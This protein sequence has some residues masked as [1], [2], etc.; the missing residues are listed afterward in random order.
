MKTH[1]AVGLA[2]ALAAGCGGDD[3]DDS[4][5]PAQL[6]VLECEIGIVGGGAA[7]IYTAYRLTPKL[8][9][10]VCLFEKE[11]ELGGRIRDTALD[12]NPDSPRIGAGARRVMET[13]EMLFALAEELGIEFEAPEQGS[14]LINAR[15]TFAFSRDAFLP[16]YPGVQGP[17]DEDEATDRETEL[18][19]L[20]RIGPERKN[21]GKYA[22]WRSYVRAVVG[23]EEF[24]FLRDMSRFKADF[25]Y[26][27][28]A[29]NYLSW[30]DEE[31]DTCCKLSYP[32]GGMSTYI[33]G[34]EKKTVAAGGRIYKSEPVL[35]ISRDAAGYLLRT[36]KHEVKV[37]RL[38]IA[39][40]P[41][42]L[43]HIE[44]EV[45]EEIRERPEYQALVPVRLTVINQWWDEAWWAKVQNPDATG[46]KEIWR[47]WTTEHCIN[48]IEIPIDA[49]GADQKV[50]RS[51]YNDDLFCAE[52]WEELLANE[53]I[54]AVEA[55]VVRGLDYLFNNGVSSPAMVGIPKPLK[56][57]M[58]V[59]PGGWYYVRAG[60]EISNQ[61]I[62][63]WSREPLPGEADVMLVGEAYWPQRPGWSIGA[64]NSAD[65]LLEA[66][67]GVTRS[68]T[69]RAQAP[70]PRRTRAGSWR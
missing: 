35:V 46:V 69:T 56:T 60:V 21:A 41:T 12:D 52:F 63:D 15:E 42:G 8:G 61:Q 28:A 31:W 6:P 22:D 62:T 50:T 32:V 59:W 51:V 17:L 1:L 23:P 27:L 64:Y 48:T 16:V 65:A 44:G 10:K 2:A 9:D 34:M 26:P 40:P 68:A 19:D 54:A 57:E 67:F 14:D 47:A 3:G 7:G 37:K 49:Y 55:E 53:G 4:G 25:T 39:A 33:T 18:Y 36:D 38:I 66:K 45:A 24:E 58:Q 30:F 13:Q 29:E 43:D 11:A 20:L 5:E 70:R